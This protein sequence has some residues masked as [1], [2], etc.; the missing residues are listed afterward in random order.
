[1]WQFH[2]LTWTAYILVC[3]TFSP[4]VLLFLLSTDGTV[5]SSMIHKECW[6]VCVSGLAVIDKAKPS[7][8]AALLQSLFS[9]SS[10]T[11]HTESECFEKLMDFMIKKMEPQFKFVFHIFSF[12]K[13]FYVP[14]GRIFT[15][16]N[17]CLPR[18][19]FFTC[20]KWDALTSSCDRVDGRTCMAVLVIFGDSMKI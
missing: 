4:T 20:I 6:L 13:W 14:L 18:E 7:P 15:L 1:M 5:S 9:Y 16:L 12:V 19:Y 11:F 17:I 3:F 8:G 2:S 10:L